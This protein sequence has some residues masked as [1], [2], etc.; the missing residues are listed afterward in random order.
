MTDD[1]KILIIL[2]VN[3]KHS[4]E[5]VYKSYYTFLIETYN[6]ESII[7]VGNDLF[8]VKNVISNVIT[9]PN[10]IETFLNAHK[11]LTT[12]GVDIECHYLNF[13]IWNNI[14]LFDEYKEWCKQHNYPI[15]EYNDF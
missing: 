15:K 11:V 10:Q 13:S 2:N 4:W 12:F 6:N 1:N 7:D 9:D 3:D 8:K 14:P 5:L